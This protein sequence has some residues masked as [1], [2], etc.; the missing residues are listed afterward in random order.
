MSVL[1]PGVVVVE[2]VVDSGSL[3]TVG[4]ALKKG[5]EIISILE[6]SHQKLKGDEQS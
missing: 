6:M 4:Y 1:S 5:K 3:I 2:T